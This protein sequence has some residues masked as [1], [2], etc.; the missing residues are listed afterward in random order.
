MVKIFKQQLEEKNLANE[1]KTKNTKTC[2][3]MAF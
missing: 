2:N 1:L 3:I